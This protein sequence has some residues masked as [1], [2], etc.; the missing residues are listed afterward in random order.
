MARLKTVTNKG[1][2]TM[3][4]TK[5]QAQY[6]KVVFALT[7]NKV[8][9]DLELAKRVNAVAYTVCNPDNPATQEVFEAF[10]KNKNFIR[11]LKSELNKLSGIQRVV[12][13]LSK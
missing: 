5:Q 7:I 1:N 10:N 2:S 11:H 8:E 3:Q 6:L 13:Q 12:K 4:L 9:D